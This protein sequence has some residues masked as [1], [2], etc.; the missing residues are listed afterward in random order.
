VLA[1][2]AALSIFAGPPALAA[3]VHAFDGHVSINRG[4]GFTHVAGDSTVH[5]GDL[6]MA[7]AHGGAEI[8]Y[9]DGCRMKVDPGSVI[10]VS[11]T[12]PCQF[13][14]NGSNL[15]LGA[16]AVAGGVGAAVILN[17]D[18]DHHPASP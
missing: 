3:T 10:R 16:A 1:A 11:D 8:V 2:V 13:G 17:S 14:S 15:L 9:D 5:P 4:D 6:V 18:N 12:S 7:G